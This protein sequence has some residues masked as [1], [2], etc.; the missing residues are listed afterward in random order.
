VENV[1]PGQDMIFESPAR[2]ADCGYSTESPDR[3]RNEL[4]CSSLMN[5]AEYSEDILAYLLKIE[6]KFRV[7]YTY[8]QRQPEV[9]SKMRSILVD[10]MIEV[11]DEYKL[12]EETL[13][14][15]ITL[16]DRFLSSM[17]IARQSF[18]LL[19]TTAL[20]IS[21]KYEE[22][23]PP[24]INEFVYITDDSYTKY[25][26]LNMEKVLLKALSFDVSSPT[27]H[28]FLQKYLC[29]LELPENVK[30]MAQYLVFL[31]LLEGEQFLKYLPSELAVSAIIL[32]ANT[33][34][35]PHLLI[36]DF[37]DIALFF[38]SD[39]AEES[40]DT[41]TA[42]RAS[43]VAELHSMQTMAVDHAQQAIYTKFSTEKYCSVSKT[44]PL[45]LPPLI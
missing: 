30:A 40:I 43:C 4:E 15:A 35:L 6:R 7:D 22:I 25:Q 17:S 33:Y 10:W 37:L 44:S 16:I 24:D 32:A 2:S 5:F 21:S 45:P 42:R 31:S 9:N 26:V 13:F 28:Y 14:L 27:S 3:Q 36:S 20:F 11:S 41:F 23:Y 39:V 34:S 19:G 8:M 29:N 1:D 12:H 18:Q 38:E